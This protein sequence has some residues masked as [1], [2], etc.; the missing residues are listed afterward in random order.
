MV[1]GG[2][3]EGIRKEGPVFQFVVLSS[4]FL[5]VT[6]RNHENCLSSIRAYLMFRVEGLKASTSSL[7]PLEKRAVGGKDKR[8]FS[9]S[10]RP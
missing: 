5:E 6:E 10:K 1:S 3:L 8:Y 7:G 2:E 4:Y 9:L